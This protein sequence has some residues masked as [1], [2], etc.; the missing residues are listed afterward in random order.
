[1]VVLQET[2]EDHGIALP[3]KAFLTPP[4]T[5]TT[6]HLIQMSIYWHECFS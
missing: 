5:T 4:T 3:V 2:R 6:P 1:M